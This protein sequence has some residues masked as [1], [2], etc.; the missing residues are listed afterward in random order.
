MKS[1]L[2]IFLFA[3]IAGLRADDFEEFLLADDAE[4]GDP[5][6]H[7]YVVCI[8]HLFTLKLW[9]FKGQKYLACSLIFL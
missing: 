2:A 4:G 6:R 7:P 3:F 8:E 9:A 5:D 1:F